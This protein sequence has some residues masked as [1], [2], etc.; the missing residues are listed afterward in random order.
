ML[1]VDIVSDTESSE[2]S[3]EHLSDQRK[4]CL[5]GVDSMVELLKGV[6]SRGSDSE[7]AVIKRFSNKFLFALKRD[8]SAIDWM[9]RRSQGSSHQIGAKIK[10]Q[11]TAPRKGWTG[12]VHFAHNKVQRCF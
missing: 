12:Y 9:A 10:V 2:S 8:S 7:L 11:P 4:E 5:Q 6:I 3:V 1:Y